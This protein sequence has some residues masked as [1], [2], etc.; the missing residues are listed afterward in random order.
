MSFDSFLSKCYMYIKCPSALGHFGSNVR[1]FRLSL[2]EEAASA[3]AAVVVATGR[4]KRNET[5][6]ANS[7][8]ESARPLGPWPTWFARSDRAICLYL[9]K[10]LYKISTR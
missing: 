2:R 10:S 1:P 4:D 9:Y 6:A 3:A 5:M 8:Q 7:G